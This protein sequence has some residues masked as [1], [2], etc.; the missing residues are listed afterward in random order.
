[1]FLCQIL[2]TA[3]ILDN[4]VLDFEVRVLTVMERQS[5]WELSVDSEKLVTY[6]SV[7]FLHITVIVLV[8]PQVCFL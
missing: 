2:F 5:S 6:K 3:W 1:M 7:T 8:K 4:D